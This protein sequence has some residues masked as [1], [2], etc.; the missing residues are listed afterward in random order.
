M[1]SAPMAIS[2]RQPWAWAIVHA[3]KDVENRSKAAIYKGGM[4]AAIGTR[5]AVHAAKG[6]TRTEYDIAAAMIRKIAG[7]CPQAHELARGGIVGTVHVT[8]VTSHHKVQIS[9][10][11]FG[12]W[13]LKLAEAEPCSFVGA[14]G[15]LGLFRWQPNGAE[16]D[17]PARWMLPRPAL[18]AIA[19]MQG[20]LL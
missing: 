8:G 9:R 11:F 19:Q 16:P 4:S 13:A 6:M 1:Q 10:W 18:E 12:P 20:E 15:A 2:V 5:I 7:D 14:T 3:G 17:P